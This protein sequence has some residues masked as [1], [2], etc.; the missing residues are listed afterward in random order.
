MS[1]LKCLVGGLRHFRALRNGG[2]PGSAPKER[3]TVEGGGKD[4]ITLTRN[5]NEIW[6]TASLEISEKGLRQFQTTKISKKAKALQ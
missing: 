4:I 5:E 2:P 3:R 1:F 6:A